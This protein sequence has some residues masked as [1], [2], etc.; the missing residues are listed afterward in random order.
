[1]E[2]VT[3]ICRQVGLWILHLEIRQ[4]YSDLTSCARPLLATTTG[5]SHSHGDRERKR[6]FAFCGWAHCQE[7]EERGL[8]STN[9]ISTFK[10]TSPTYCISSSWEY[11]LHEDNYRICLLHFFISQHS[12][13]NIIGL[14]WAFVQWMLL[15]HLPSQYII[16]KLLYHS[17][18]IFEW[19]SYDYVR[20]TNV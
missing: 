2:K 4:T 18:Y 16:L 12:T 15:V 11:K 17:F 7:E 6:A 1:M 19:I 10:S 20:Y 5:A 14:Q 13:Y 9:S 8:G 3:Y